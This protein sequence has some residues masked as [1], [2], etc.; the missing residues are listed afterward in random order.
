MADKKW[1]LGYG[2]E[3][4]IVP[5]IEVGKLDGADLIITKDTKRIVFVRPDKTVLFTK[6][7]LETFDSIESANTYLTTESVY[8]GELISVLMHN[9]YKTYRVQQSESGFV[10]E[11]IETESKE[12]IKVVD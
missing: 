1:R 2:N 5:A 10:L 6:S 8:A 11:D 9:K 3:S 4:A 7:K 12:Y